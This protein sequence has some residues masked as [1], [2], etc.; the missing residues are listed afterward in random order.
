MENNPIEQIQ[1]AETNAEKAIKQAHIQA[2]ETLTKADADALALVEQATDAAQ[3][4]AAAGLA[5][6][7]AANRISMEKA[8][9]DIG[10]ET[11]ALADTARAAQPKAIEKILEALA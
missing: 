5:A 8:Q 2:A 4:A 7:H 9:A 11:D 10:K 3:K 6:A 1:D